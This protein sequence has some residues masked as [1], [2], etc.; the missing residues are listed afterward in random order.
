MFRLLS[1]MNKKNIGAAHNCQIDLNGNARIAY[2]QRDCECNNNLFCYSVFPFDF[3]CVRVRS[4]CLLLFG[5]L[6]ILRSISLFVVFLFLP[7]SPHSIRFLWVFSEYLSVLWQFLL[8]S[9]YCIRVAYGWLCLFTNINLAS[10]PA[11][12]RWVAGCHCCLQI[13][14]FHR[15]ICE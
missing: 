2:F 12:K 4:F 7:W 10:H 6:F 8:V 11:I 15:K 5:I 14:S 1:R 13:K 3:F 9:A